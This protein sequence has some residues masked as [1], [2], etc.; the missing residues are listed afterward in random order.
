[1]PNILVLSFALA[2]SSALL[3]GGV[4]W[5][6]LKRRVEAAYERGL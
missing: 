4:A 1:M 5:L 2:L 3:G 6:A